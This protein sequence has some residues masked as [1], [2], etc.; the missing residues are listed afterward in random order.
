MGF[1]VQYDGLREVEEART[2]MLAFDQ[3]V[4]I[5]R[6]LRRRPSSP[7]PPTI[8]DITPCINLL[9]SGKGSSAF[10]AA[11]RQ[12]RPLLNADTFAIRGIRQVGMGHLKQ[13][14]FTLTGQG[15]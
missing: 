5:P 11:W 3:N 10:Q 15:G 12:V 7:M 9:R 1:Y 6:V 14:P 8:M 2:S 4:D 13:C